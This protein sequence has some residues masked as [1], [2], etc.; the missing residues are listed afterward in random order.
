MSVLYQNEHSGCFNYDRSEKPQIEVERVVKGDT[1]ILSLKENEI[2]FITEGRIRFVSNGLSNC[3]GL[4]G[5]M[6]FLPA[7]RNYSFEALADSAITI[8]RFYESIRLCDN[9]DLENLNKEKAAA[10][11]YQ[12][13]SERLRILNINIILWNYL[14]GLND[15]IEEGMRCR[16][17]FQIKIKE[18]LLLLH[19][20]YTKEELQDFFSPI[21][22]DDMF[23]FRICKAPLERL[24]YNN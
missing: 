14:D 8:F 7:G 11:S 16:S 22:S 5:Q 9:F 6:L 4:K 24:P 18:L 23:F 10:S 21:L 20:F 12:P 1:G 17:F 13:G 2:V 3:D 15:L 19:S